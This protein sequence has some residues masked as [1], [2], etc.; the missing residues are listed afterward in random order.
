MWEPDEKK[1][2]L[3]HKTSIGYRQILSIA[4]RQL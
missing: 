1:R 3:D 4:V 2:D